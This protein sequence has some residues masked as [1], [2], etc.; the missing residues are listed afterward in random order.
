M[1]IIIIK[2]V[3]QSNRYSVQLQWVVVVILIPLLCTFHYLFN[4][5]PFLFTYLLISI[6]F[7]SPTMNDDATGQ[8][9][10]I[11]NYEITL[12]V[13]PIPSIP[14]SEDLKVSWLILTSSYRHT[15]HRQ[16]IQCI[17]ISVINASSIFYGLCKY[18]IVTYQI[19]T[20]DW[21]TDCDAMGWDREWWWWLWIGR[22]WRPDL[23]MIAKQYTFMFH[24]FHQQPTLNRI[25]T[26]WMKWRERTLVSFI[27]LH[28]MKLHLSILIFVS[29]ASSAAASA[30]GQ[31]LQFRTT[32]LIVHPS[33]VLHSGKPLS[34]PV[35][36]APMPSLEFIEIICGKWVVRRRQHARFDLD[37]S[38]MEI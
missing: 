1:F 2:S 16:C 18:W 29:L 26:D 28:S 32:I 20:S 27:A 21:L 13:H 8:K 15:I 12:L 25:A 36:G 7:N 11:T 17:I 37:V 30:L 23:P 9:E 33:A 14:V 6:S 3:L 22:I 5:S 31:I 35:S 4:A 24:N 34:R 10:I 38:W 19:T